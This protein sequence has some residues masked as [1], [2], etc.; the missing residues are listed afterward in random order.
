M[1]I[2]TQ[3]ILALVLRQMGGK[4]LVEKKTFIEMEEN[5]EII[6]HKNLDENLLI[7]LVDDEESVANIRTARAA[8]QE[9]TRAL[10]RLIVP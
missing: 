3:Q 7:S 5:F 10:G 9:R 4:V 1:S 6:F 2:D 8:E